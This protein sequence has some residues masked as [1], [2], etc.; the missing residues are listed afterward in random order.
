MQTDQDTEIAV[1][2]VVS[3]RVTGVGFRYCTCAE[4]RRYPGLKGYVRNIARGRVECHLQGCPD[5]V[6]A[7]R[8]W[9]RGGPET[10]VVEEFVCEDIAPDHRMGPFQVRF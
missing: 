2:V 6:R 8:Q 4:A 3:G 10:A 1:R 7:M 5:D 9:L